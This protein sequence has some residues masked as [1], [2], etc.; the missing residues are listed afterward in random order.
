M[1]GGADASTAFV[2]AAR[3]VATGPEFER[4]DA[5]TWF[6]TFR[7][8]D[9]RLAR[10][11][12]GETTAIVAVIDATGIIGVSVGNSEAWVVTGPRIDRLTHSQSAKRLGSGRAA[13]VVFH[14]S[15]LDG[16]LIIASD[17]LFEQTSEAVIAAACPSGSAAAVA[18]ALMEA[19]R[20]PSGALADD[21][22]VV[23][24][25]TRT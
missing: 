17:G 12:T 11:T 24:V 6:Q 8:I 19:A 5:R 16:V 20:L 4:H 7:A 10:M 9:A 21:V 1:G 14:R 22:S 18:D 15:C 2:D 13:P 25:R 23:V 3:A